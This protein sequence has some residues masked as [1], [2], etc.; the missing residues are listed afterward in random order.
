MP[1]ASE[2]DL[3]AW[4]ITAQVLDS[5]DPAE[6]ELLPDIAESHFFPT[7]AISAT[8]GAF[9]FD[10]PA[11]QTIASS[12]LPVIVAAIAFAAPKVFDAALDLTKETL[13]KRLSTKSNE[14]FSAGR[15]VTFNSAA[16]T[17]VINDA[18]RDRRLAKST[19]DAIVNAVLSHFA[20]NLA[21]TEPTSKR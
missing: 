21:G 14:A 1:H 12:I 13:K 4:T 15:E 3:I 7:K 19:T 18:A 6:A 2:G 17:K 5:I 11:V 16:L 10:L 20:T 8:P 9:E